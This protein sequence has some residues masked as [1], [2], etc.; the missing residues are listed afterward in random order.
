MKEKEVAAHLQLSQSYSLLGAHFARRLEGWYIKDALQRS[1]QFEEVFVI[2]DY[3]A[4]GRRNQG[5]RGERR[6]QG[7]WA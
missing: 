5:G 1:N 7:S 2:A 3:G 4:V 6:G